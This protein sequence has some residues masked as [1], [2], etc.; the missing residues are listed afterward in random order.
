MVHLT[1][2]Q[3]NTILLLVYTCHEEFLDKDDPKD[4]NLYEV[5]EAEVMARHLV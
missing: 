3:L 2:E 4:M 1:E 5:L